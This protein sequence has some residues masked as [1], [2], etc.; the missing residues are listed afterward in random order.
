MEIGALEMQP[1]GFRVLMARF[2]EVVAIV[3]TIP[4]SLVQVHFD[5]RP[6]SARRQPRGHEFHRPLIRKILVFFGGLHRSVQ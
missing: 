5:A 6:S 3:V 2:V 4:P 1:T